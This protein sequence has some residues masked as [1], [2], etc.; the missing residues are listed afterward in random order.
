MPL[1]GDPSGFVVLWEE[2][3]KNPYMGFQGVLDPTRV[4]LRS[5]DL[6]EGLSNRDGGDGE[7]G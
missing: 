7:A 3:L 5:S 6:R 4:Y 1:G 2:N